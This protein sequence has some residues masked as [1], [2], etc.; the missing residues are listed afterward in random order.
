M[1]NQEQKYHLSLAG[2]FYVAAELQ[3]RGVSAAVTYGNAK[4]ADVV[5]FSTSGEKVVVIEVKSTSQTKWVVG[6]KVPLPSAK[7]WVFVH[8]PSERTAPPSFFIVLQSELYNILAPK[9]TEY[10][11]K[12]K[13]K[14]GDEYGNR[15]GV[16]NLT[17]QQAAPFK[18]AWEKIVD[19]LSTEPATQRRSG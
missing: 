8:M 5:A 11:R 14:H 1:S 9:A 4:S 6:N 16:E 15:R 10:R 7:P 13:E 18:D 17:K 12:F 3:R 19:Q 2:E